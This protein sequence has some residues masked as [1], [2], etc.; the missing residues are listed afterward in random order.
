MFPPLCVPAAEGEVGVDGGVALES[1][2]TE[3]G[4]KIV[5]SG[6]F[7]VGFKVVEW[8]EKIQNAKASIFNQGSKA[9][10]AQ[11]EL[12][13]VTTCEAFNSVKATECCNSIIN[14]C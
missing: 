5:S 7:K 12:S 8:Y 11:V 10:C 4:E 6:G 14:A 13:N 9:N 3:D 2:L 1:Y